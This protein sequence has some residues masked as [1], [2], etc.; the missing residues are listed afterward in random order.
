MLKYFGNSEAFFRFVDSSFRVGD[1]LVAEPAARNL[2]YSS[3]GRIN[4][5]HR[6]W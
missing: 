5:L 4:H 3:A 6:A 2:T 1:S